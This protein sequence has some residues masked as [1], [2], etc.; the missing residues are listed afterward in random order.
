MT[1]K[2][3]TVDESVGKDDK[4]AGMHHFRKSGEWLNQLDSG[5]VNQSDKRRVVVVVPIDRRLLNIVP[6]AINP[7]TLLNSAY[8]LLC[9]LIHSCLFH[10]HCD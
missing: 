8:S 6:L 9:K 7:K 5:V 4:S 10:V 3:L 2:K 1:D